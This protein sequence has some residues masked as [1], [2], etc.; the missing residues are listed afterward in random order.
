MNQ[1]N[2]KRRGMLS[3]LTTEQAALCARTGD[4][5][6]GIIKAFT[7][8]DKHYIKACQALGVP[9]KILDV[10]G[11]DWMEVIHRAECHAFLVTPVKD[12]SARRRMFDERLRIIS[13]ELGQTVFP[14]YDEIWLYESKRRMHYWLEANCMAHPSTWVY[15]DQREALAFA[16]A[17]PLP[18]VCRAD[19]GSGAM[20]IEMFC[21]RSKL[22]RWVNRCFK[23]GMARLGG[24][25]RGCQ[26]TSVSFQEYLPN[27]TEWRMIRIGDSYMGYQR[28]HCSGSMKD[29]KPFTCACPPEALL[30]FVRRVTCQGGFKSMAM[31][32]FETEDGHYFVNKLKTTFGL[33]VKDGLPM[34]EGNPGRFLF[35]DAANT[36]RFEEGMFC[37][38]QL[39]NLRV[40]TVLKQL[41]GDRLDEV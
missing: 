35:D 33:P 37:Q 7:C 27:V 32:I 5:C 20:G 25:A 8:I 13:H 39:C 31:D 22:I 34:K 15:Y 36:W 21:V 30:Q 4:V 2:R 17:T 41:E 14:S 9:Y 3:T 11:A 10:S 1:R 18:I 24:D 40:L 38:N 23:T 26:W 12:S 28:S 29:A 16:D 6:L 19:F